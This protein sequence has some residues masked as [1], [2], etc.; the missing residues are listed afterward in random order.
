MTSHFSRSFNSVRVGALMK[1]FSIPLLLALALVVNACERH[2]ASSLPSHGA[3]GGTADHGAAPGGEG[4]KKEEPAMPPKDGG[5]P[6][7]FEQQSG[8]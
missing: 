4:H 8:K 3:H 7:F 6:K 2:S 5:A 1:R